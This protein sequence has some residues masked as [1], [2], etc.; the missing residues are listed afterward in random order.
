MKKLYIAG[1]RGMVGKAL[2]REAEK[3]GGYQIVTTTRDQLDL[4]DQTVVFN[5]LDSEKPDIVIIAA[6]KVGGI[7]ANST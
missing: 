6:A 5:Y 4:C 1:H 2:V 3:A 7:H